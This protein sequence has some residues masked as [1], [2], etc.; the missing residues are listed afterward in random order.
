MYNKS[1]GFYIAKPADSFI[2]YNLFVKLF[3]DIM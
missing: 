2:K 1:A 3:L